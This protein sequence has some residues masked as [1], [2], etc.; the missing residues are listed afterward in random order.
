[1]GNI[2]ALDVQVVFTDED[3]NDI[4]TCRVDLVQCANG[5]QTILVYRTGETRK[6]ARARAMLDLCEMN[7][8]IS[9]AILCGVELSAL[10]DIE[11]D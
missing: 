11:E 1:M 3:I 9:E 2:S 10:A 5:T 7:R 8:A 6:E 4:P